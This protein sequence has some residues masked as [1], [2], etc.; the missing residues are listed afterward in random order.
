M[1]VHAHKQCAAWGD[2]TPTTEFAPIEAFIPQRGKIFHGDWLADVKLLQTS[3][4]TLGLLSPL[5]VIK[6]R[7][8]LHVVD[9]KKRLAAIRRLRFQGRLPRHL[10]RIPYIILQDSMGLESPV[11]MLL[12]NREL[13]SNVVDAHRNGQS[14]ESIAQK[15]FLPRTSVREILTLARLSSRLRRYFFEGHLDLP[16]AKAYASIPRQLVQDSV[17]DQVGAFASVEDVLTAASEGKQPARL[18]EAA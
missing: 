13:Y 7:G 12:T 1:M 2:R 16:Q 17:F 14:V 5:I 15:L 3:I 10:V 8:Q 18:S 9:G 4:E 6:T 11:A